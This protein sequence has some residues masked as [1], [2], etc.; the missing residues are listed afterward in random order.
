MPKTIAI[1]YPGEMGAHVAALIRALG[2]RVVTASSGRSRETLDRAMV[3]GIEILPDIAAVIAVS[4]I[5]LSIVVPDAALTVA[6]E[7][8]Q[9]AS[10]APVGAIYIDMNSIG[11]ELAVSI[12]DLFQDSPVDFVDGSING[13]AR[14]LA[15]SGTVFLSGPRAAEVADLFTG[16]ARVRV[17]G[18]RIGSASMAKM[19]LAGLSKGVC[20]LFI[21]IALIAEKDGTLGGFLAACNEIYP[22]IAALIERMVPTYSEHAGRRKVEMQQLELTASAADINAD[23]IA[24]VAKLHAELAE[25]SFEKSSASLTAEKWI[26]ALANKITI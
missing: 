11:P 3:S 21:E 15:Q 14:N 19:L 2:H 16:A 20:A 5:I 18:D 7:C 12:A 4:D 10:R 25:I 8:A 24:G 26:E 17:L 22:G 23:V 6:K 13:L 1:L 9:L